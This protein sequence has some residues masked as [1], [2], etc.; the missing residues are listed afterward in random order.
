MAF[1]AYRRRSDETAYTWEGRDEAA[2]IIGR[3]TPSEEPPFATAQTLEEL[4][5][6]VW[7]Y[8]GK[9]PDAFVYLADSEG[10][11]R[12]TMHCEKYHEAVA[13]AN[14]WTIITAV[15]LVF[16]ITCLIGA[17]SLPH[18]AVALLGFIGA[19][20]LYALMLRTGFQ[21]EIE[22]AVVCEIFLIL[23]LL[24]IRVCELRNQLENQSPPRSA[25]VDRIGQTE[26][27]PVP[28]E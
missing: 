23:I 13:R 28:R 9:H 3:R 17:W 21:N 14:S 19:V 18:G 12:A 7:A 24:L 6:E 11:V 27:P 5:Q 15:L 4:K 26:S 20:A 1:A 16:S 2:G 25:A 8:L 10:N 22:G